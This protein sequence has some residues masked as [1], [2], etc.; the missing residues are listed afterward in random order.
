MNRTLFLEAIDNDV[1]GLAKALDLSVRDVFDLINDEGF[2]GRDW[3]VIKDK[4]K[5]TDS[6]I[7]EILFYA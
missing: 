3:L 4:Y 1:S 6:Q 7:F 5:L 2:A